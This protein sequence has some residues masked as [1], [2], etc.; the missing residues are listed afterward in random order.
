MKQRHIAEILRR[1]GASEKLV[2]DMAYYLSVVNPQFN[3][4][5]FTEAAGVEESCGYTTP[6]KEE[7][8][9][10]QQERLLKYRNGW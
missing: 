4:R 2:R 3:W 5:K 9:E 6:Q 1:H 7:T 10:T 8:W